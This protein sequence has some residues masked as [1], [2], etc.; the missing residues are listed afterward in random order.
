[1]VLH[2]GR[3]LTTAKVRT[4]GF[5][6]VFPALRGVQAGREYFVTMCPLRLI[7]RLFVFDDEEL[8][9][10]MRAQRSLNRN[11][12]PEIAR[13]MAQNPTNYVFSALTASVDADVSFESFTETGSN[14]RVGILTIPMSAKF[15]IN[16]GQHRRAAIQQALSESPHLGDETI[17]IVLFLDVGLKRCQQM[18]ADLNR[19]AIRPAKSISVLYDHRD[20]M[21]AITRVTVFK[22]PFY[23]DLTEAESNNLAARS[24]KLFT[25]SGFYNA[26]K[27][28]LDG[29]AEDSFE[30]RVDLATAFWET[31]ARQFPEWG[32]VRNREVSAGEVRRD[33]I[34]SHG[35]VLHAIGKVGNS[36]LRQTLERRTWEKT[37]KRLDS[38]DWHRSNSNLW[39]GRATSGGRVS[40]S[41]GN[42]LLTTAV[43]RKALGMELSAD[44]QRAENALTRGEA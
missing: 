19:Y 39:E 41:T 31:V 5:E 40:K 15:V 18:F 24:R 33:F 6:Y 28:L 35:I 4:T 34:H 10:E 20:E 43:I 27:A 30:R 37:L 21:S 32:Q 25:L 1:M 29:V 36:L 44:E 16:D 9:P 26:N 22:S 3:E 12:V 42:V 23:S 2:E 38:I 17:A 14:E 7:P 8:A 13:Y 11:R